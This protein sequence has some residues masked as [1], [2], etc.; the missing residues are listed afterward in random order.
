VESTEIV[1]RVSAAVAERLS[2]RR[3]IRKGSDYMFGFG[4]LLAAGKLASSKGPGV[5][6]ACR[7]VSGT[8]D[9][10]GP[11][12]PYGCGPSA[13]CNA[14]GR[15]SACQCGTGG[16]CKNGVGNCH[17]SDGYC[18]TCKCVECLPSGNVE[19]TTTCCDCKSGTCGDFQGVCISYSRTSR[20]IGPCGGRPAKVPVG[21][22]IAI[23]T[24]DPRTSWSKV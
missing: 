6:N 20:V 16:T 23:D 11:G 19:F 13:C 4:A 18:W 9:S 8:C 5:H 22:V 10:A 2:R 14:S 21:T 15:S 12:C 3:F 24:G 7:R 1:Q 17:G